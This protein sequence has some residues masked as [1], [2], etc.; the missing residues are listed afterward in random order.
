MC[1]PPPTALTCF[2]G[3]F[4][5]RFRN[6]CEGFGC[7]RRRAP[8]PRESTL[9]APL[10]TSLGSRGCYLPIVT[11]LKTQ[12]ETSVPRRNI[13][14]AVQQLQGLFI[15][16]G[17]FLLSTGWLALCDVICWCTLKTR[18]VLDSWVVLP[19]IQITPV[20]PA[21]P[22]QLIRL[23]CGC[24]D[25]VSGDA[26]LVAHKVWTRAFDLR[27]SSTSKEGSSALCWQPAR[28]VNAAGTRW[29]GSAGSAICYYV[30]R[31]YSLYNSYGMVTEAR[32]P[33]LKADNLNHVAVDSWV[34]HNPAENKPGMRP[35]VEPEKSPREGS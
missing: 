8:A 1:K 5:H 7:C 14:D 11:H 28:T 26:N 18:V 16:F 34:E 21:S 32:S 22:P 13:I 30:V 29:Y 19:L 10:V 2:F 35:A 12:Q 6:F 33:S 23:E 25:R 3:G 24:R 31:L 17:R 9:S 15:I 4:L 27:I 20:Q